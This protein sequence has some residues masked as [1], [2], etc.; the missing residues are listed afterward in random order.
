VQEREHGNGDDNSS[1]EKADEDQIVTTDTDIPEITK[2]TTEERAEDIAEGGAAD[3]VAAQ[4]EA[5][6]SSPALDQPPDDSK[7][8]AQDTSTPVEQTINMQ[9]NL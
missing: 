2:E 5:Q 9:V 4:I 7:L 3:T 1:N 6:S 8:E